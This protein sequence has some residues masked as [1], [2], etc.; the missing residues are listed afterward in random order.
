MDQSP[1]RSI[2]GTNHIP[3][4][5]E[6]ERIAE[7]L[8]EPDTQLAEL[9]D[10]ISEQEEKLQKLKKR[11]Q[12]LQEYIKAHRVIISLIRQLPDDVLR[13]IFVACLPTDRY[14]EMR[15]EEPPMLLSQVCKRWRE[16]ALS[17]PHLWSSLH[18]WTSPDPDLN[19][20]GVPQLESDWE[21][22]LEW[23]ENMILQ[24][25]RRG[26]STPLSISFRGRHMQGPRKKDLP[27]INDMWR[28]FTLLSP[29]FSRLQKLEVCLDGTENEIYEVATMEGCGGRTA[30]SFVEQ[31]NLRLNLRRQESHVD[32]DE[33]KGDWERLLKNLGL[34]LKPHLR[35]LG[36]HF[37]GT[38]TNLDTETSWFIPF[39]PCNQLEVLD[40]QGPDPSNAG[41]NHISIISLPLLLQACPKLVVFKANVSFLLPPPTP[42]N[43][44]SRIASDRLKEVSLFF[45]HWRSDSR[46]FEF[47]A[48]CDWPSLTSLYLRGGG[49]NSEGT[50]LLSHMVDRFRSTLTSLRLSSDA[51]TPETLTNLM[52]KL[53]YLVQLHLEHPALSGPYTRFDRS[54]N[55]YDRRLEDGFDNVFDHLIPKL[56]GTA[57]P[58]P[59]LRFLKWERNT[60][61]SD[62]ALARLLR[63]RA[64]SP[65]SS[66]RLKQVHIVF[67]RPAE[68]DILPMCSDLIDAG[69][70]LRLMYTPSLK[71]F[72]EETGYWLITPPR[73]LDMDYR[74]LGWD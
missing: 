44:T 46:A 24:W 28:L 63:E 38:N 6:R 66:V 7:F 1:F 35:K 41:S 3:T 22:Q 43:S 51:I 61:F 48:R 72:T 14:P 37:E 52:F 64:N 31:L 74:T 36:L 17:T 20:E 2:L 33:L 39:V 16:V 68:E 70:D 53:P 45:L 30:F 71:G 4:E 42:T 62:K 59:H 8:I 27:N 15:A 60:Q 25:I 29:S 67:G 49:A 32:P 56:E 9:Q 21:S 50:D 54:S 65:Y 5:R 11:C 55:I 40:L 34:N 18:I 47:M 13:E 26:G 10:I 19:D 73:P 58:L 23:Q 57:Y 12:K 69:L